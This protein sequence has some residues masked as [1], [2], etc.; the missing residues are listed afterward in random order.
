MNEGIA[1]Y[2]IS[3]SLIKRQ[4]PQYSFTQTKQHITFDECKYIAINVIEIK[5]ALNEPDPHTFD[6]VM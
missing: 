2:D 5:K 3:L 6:P 1:S 4:T